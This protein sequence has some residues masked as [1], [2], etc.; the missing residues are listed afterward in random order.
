MLMGGVE[1]LD[2]DPW[3]NLRGHFGETGAG[4]EGRVLE[5]YSFL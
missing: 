2:E 1:Y 5:R 4:Q 3:M